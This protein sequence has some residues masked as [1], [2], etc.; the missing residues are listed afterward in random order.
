MV[1]FLN[2]E[3]GKNSMDEYFTEVQKENL[4]YFRENL[5]DFLKNPLYKY[6]FAIIANNEIAGIF[7]TFNNA[8]EDAAS[9]FSQG[10]Y[11]IQ[12]II[13]ENEVINFLY[14]AIA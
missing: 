6:K 11:I 9:R 13:G 8:I 7:D 5:A 1:S 4:Q 3:G 2:Y 12:Q 14:P 10:E